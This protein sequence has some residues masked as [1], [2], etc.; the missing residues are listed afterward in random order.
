MS[1][2]EQEIASQPQM[3]RA[4]AAMA[5][6]AR[7]VLPA[8]GARIAVLGC[9]TSWFMAQS[10]AALREAAGLGET[11]AFT[12]TEM[13]P[14][15]RYDA[16]V[17][18]SRS[19]TTTEIVRA[20]HAAPPGTPTIAI[21]AV[22][23]SPVVQA[24]ARSIFLEAADE[25]SVVQTRFAT[26]ALALFRAAFGED[27]RPAIADAA[28]ALAEPLPFDPVA[29]E[30]FV[31]LGRA[32]TVGLANEAALK[33]REACQAWTE[34]YPAMEY[35]HGPISV[36][37]PHSVVWA[38]GDIEAELLAQV[39]RTGATVVAGELDPMAEL[40]RIHRVAGR[41]AAAK[42]LDPDQPRHLTRSVVLES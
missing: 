41:L 6:E 27:L 10:V 18:I 15:R 31:F 20:L 5:A 28:R 11:D 4:A 21:S 24:A 23:D 35:R 33:L 26:T 39:A 16:V 1:A 37:E 32:W 12:P 30:H 29:F 2:L 17:V 40:V 14:G 34:A 42:G 13:P 38:L 25:Q 3:W 7:E 22:P 36:A 8:A 19:G 9:G